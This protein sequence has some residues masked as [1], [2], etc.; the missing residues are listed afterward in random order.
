M[1]IEKDKTKDEAAIRELIDGFVE[2]VRAKDING[3]ISVFA[4]EIVSF[5]LGSPLQHGGG[6]TFVRRWQELFE[7]Y[8]NPIDYEVRELHG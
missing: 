2:A 1:T 6:E 5:D 8:Q 4:P 7:S 3:V